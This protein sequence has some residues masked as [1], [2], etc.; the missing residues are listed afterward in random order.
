[1]ATHEDEARSGPQLIPSS[2]PSNENMTFF[3]TQFFA[4]GHKLPT[5]A[6]VRDADAKPR[7]KDPV[8]FPA[9]N[10]IVKYGGRIKISEGQCLWAIRRLCPNV[11]VPEVYGWRTD[12]GQTFIYME[13]IEAPTLEAAWPELDAEEKNEICVQLRSIIN[14]LRQLRQDPSNQFIGKCKQHPRTYLSLI[15][16]KY[17]KNQSRTCNGCDF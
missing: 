13:N 4:D 2:L 10:L 15:V 6:E 8:V 17:R 3:D 12:E 16:L 11:P 7:S 1:M 14:E 5:P 9:M